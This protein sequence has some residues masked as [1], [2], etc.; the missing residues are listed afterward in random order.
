MSLLPI[1]IGGLKDDDAFVRWNAAT[2][3][4]DM[5][6]AAAPALTAL[7]WALHD[8]DDGVQMHAAQ[9]LGNV[10]AA[11]DRVV[12]ALI[13]LLREH[14]TRK[15]QTQGERLH[16]V[17]HAALHCFGAA[18]VPFLTKALGENGDDFRLRILSVLGHLGH[19]AAPACRPWR[20]CSS[21]KTP[22]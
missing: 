21:M 6:P 18:A 16:L 19:L 4:A 15:V 5:G 14:S 11:A 3:L 7:E 2:T 10:G 9:A 17:V 1:L 12:P 13:S 20:T 22:P 8:R